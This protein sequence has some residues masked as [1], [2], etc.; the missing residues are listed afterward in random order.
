MEILHYLVKQKER[1]VFLNNLF[2]LTLYQLSHEHNWLLGTRLKLY[3][4]PNYHL[5]DHT[6]DTIDH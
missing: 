3:P 2:Y 5:Q 6:K 4:T 1:K